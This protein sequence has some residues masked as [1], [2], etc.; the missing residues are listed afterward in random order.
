MEN[1]FNLVDE[2]WI[3]VAD[4]GRVSLTQL[5]GD[6]DYR[7]LGGNP[8]QKIALM[9]LLLAIAQ[10]A[11]TPTDEWEWRELGPLGL[12]RACLAYL[13]RWRDRFFL[14]GDKPFLQ[15][16]AIAKARILNY[17]AL[18]PEISTGNA[19]ILNHAQIER[20]LDDA[21]RALLLVVLMG[22][23]LGGKKTDNRVVLTPEYQGKTN[24]KGKPDGKARTGS[25]T[26]GSVAQFPSG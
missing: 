14:Y 9:K 11:I 2:P 24:D 8:I 5:F 16:P 25:C 3:P 22:F 7:S 10:A 1:R 23:A 12:S 15:M 6:P 17:G 26:Y 19:T 4:V 18:L 20:P 13:D 21:D